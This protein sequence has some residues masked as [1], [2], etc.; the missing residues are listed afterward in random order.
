MT[1]TTPF[2]FANSITQISSQ[3]NVTGRPSVDWH[4]DSTGIS[5]GRYAN[6]LGPIHSI[7]GFWQ[8]KFFSQTSEL[9]A[10]Q[11]NFPLV[12]GTVTGIELQLNVLRVARI[13][14]LVIQ[15]TLNGELI[16]DNRASI[17]NPVQSDMY[18]ADTTVPLIPIQ[19]E[20]IYGGPNDLW[21]TALNHTDISN[22]TFGAT[23]SFRSN[24]IYPHNDIVYVDQLALRI[25]YA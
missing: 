11:F 14:D 2:T 8:E 1:I 20:N 9:Q 19:D 4:F 10:T 18:T 16:G 25:T 6:T 13:Q 21:G 17:V 5:E 22:P 7:S 24:I 15:L 12:N 23:I 3:N